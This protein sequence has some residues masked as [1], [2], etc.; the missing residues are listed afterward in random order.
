MAGAKRF[1]AIGWT[2]TMAWQSAGPM[3]WSFAVWGHM[4]DL[5][6][7]HAICGSDLAGPGKSAKTVGGCRSD[8]FRQIGATGFARLGVSP[9]LA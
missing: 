5:K 9:L 6:P 4:R 1:D 2:G 8:A 3:K 7:V